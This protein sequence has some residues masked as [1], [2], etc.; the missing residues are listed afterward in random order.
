MTL[1][2]ICPEH[3]FLT[4]SRFSLPFSRT[5]SSPPPPSPFLECYLRQFL[6]FPPVLPEAL[7]S[8]RLPGALCEPQCPWLLGAEQHRL[9]VHLWSLP[10]GLQSQACILIIWKWTVTVGKGKWWQGKCGGSL[11][12]LISTKVRDLC[13]PNPNILNDFSQEFLYILTRKYKCLGLGFQKPN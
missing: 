3:S 10:K 11:S 9:R 8:G 12:S 2:C 4:P 6:I 13:L 1:I 5:C 7:R